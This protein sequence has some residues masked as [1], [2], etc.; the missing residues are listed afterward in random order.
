M[1]NPKFTKFLAFGQNDGLFSA[2]YALVE[3]DTFNKCME[4]SQILDFQFG[5]N[6]TKFRKKSS[7]TWSQKDKG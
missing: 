3:V 6:N 5:N 7:V 2:F 1:E 4:T